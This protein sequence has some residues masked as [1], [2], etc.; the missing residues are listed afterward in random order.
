MKEIYVV[1]S[2]TDLKT[3]RFIRKVT[4][5]KYNHACISTDG[6]KTL[7]SFSRL[8]LDHPMLAGFVEE[9]PNRYLM[10]RQ[11][12]VKVVKIEVDNN[13]YAAVLQYIRR[14]QSN[15]KEYVY[16]YLSCAGY[17]VGKRIRRDK[18]YTCVEFVR[19]ALVCAGVLPSSTSCVKIPT[20]E[21]ELKEYETTEGMAKEI[22]CDADW[23][24]DD[25]LKNFGGRIRVAREAYRRLW[26]MLLNY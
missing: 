17:P 11:A 2:G 19:D 5:Q 13:T 22:F 20:L 21:A 25:Y 9:S 6:L 23:G 15:P 10:M 3:G 14:M 4:H 18:A 24:S 16:N 8:Y 7:C 12:C 1:F 26:H